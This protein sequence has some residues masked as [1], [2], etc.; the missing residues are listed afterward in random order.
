[1]VYVSESGIGKRLAF[2]DSSLVKVSPLSEGL[3]DNWG[4]EDC[5]KLVTTVTDCDITVDSS[6]VE[7]FSKIEN[8][9][10]VRYNYYRPCYHIT[11]RLAGKETLEDGSMVF[12][13]RKEVAA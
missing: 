1:M 3:T 10:F 6:I 13:Y 9:S 5:I 4:D 8:L 11:G 2:D 7:D 12:H